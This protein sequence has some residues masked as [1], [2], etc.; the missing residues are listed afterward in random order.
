MGLS[1]RLL[2]GDDKFISANADKACEIA[3]VMPPE[4]TCLFIVR[5]MVGNTAVRKAILSAKSAHKWVTA[6]SELIDRYGIRK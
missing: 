3:G 2:R 4:I 6:H 5:S 1:S